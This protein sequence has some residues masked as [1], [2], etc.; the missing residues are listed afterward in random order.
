MF[1]FRVS[2]HLGHP[3]VGCSIGFSQRFKFIFFCDYGFCFFSEGKDRKPS[4][5]KKYEFEPLV[6][7]LGLEPG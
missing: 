4:E 1:V 6:S 3:G 5:S 7:H 2:I